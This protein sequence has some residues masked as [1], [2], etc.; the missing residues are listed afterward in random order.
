MYS[1]KNAQTGLALY[2]QSNDLNSI[3][4]LP[5]TGELRHAIET[6]QLSFDYQPQIELE[7][8][9]ACGIAVEMVSRTTFESSASVMAARR[10]SVPAPG[11][12]TT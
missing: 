12:L 10:R 9:R 3:R 7:S 6:N 2:D 4:H 5:L 8:R 11:V 1:A